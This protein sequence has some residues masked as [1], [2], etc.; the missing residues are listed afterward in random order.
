MFGAVWHEDEVGDGPF[1][2]ILA[3]LPNKRKPR[4][5]TVS[6]RE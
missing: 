4:P 5:T 6:E 2:V 3:N 1:E